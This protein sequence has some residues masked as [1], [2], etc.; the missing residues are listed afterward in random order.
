M[1]PYYYPTRKCYRV[2]VPAEHSETGK[3]YPKYFKTEPAA[4]EFIDGLFEVDRVSHGTVVAI[5]QA[6]AYGLTAGEIEAPF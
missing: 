5:A 1:T 3:R 6:D 4:Q 2:Q